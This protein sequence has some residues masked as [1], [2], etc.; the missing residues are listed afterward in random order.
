MTQPPKKDHKNL[1]IYG[2]FILL[3]FTLWIPLLP[4]ITFWLLPLPFLLFAANSQPSGLL[5]LFI[6]I[7]GGISLLFGG[8]ILAAMII[9]A[10]ITGSTMGWI[11]QRKDTTGLEVFMSGLIS[12]AASLLVLTLIANHLYGLLDFFQEML[13]EQWTAMGQLLQSYGMEDEQLLGDPLPISM[14]LPSM[15]TYLSLITSL[16]N[17]WIGRRILL[18]WK[19]PGKYLPPFRNWR[20][21]RP[22]FF[23][24]FIVTL[25]AFFTEAGESYWIT[26][27]SLQLL[28]WQLFFLQ[29]FAFVAFLL[30][31]AGKGRI[32]LA[33]V[34]AI[35]LLLPPVALIIHIL[36]ILDTG[37]QIRQFLQKGKK[38]N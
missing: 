25:I 19:F 30:H 23:F 36:G 5:P 2:L 15:I 37:T 24:Y 17:L 27:Q 10:A 16:I 26:I 11:Y 33:L 3:L 32:W 6:L 7:C 29:G 20:L 38:K 12:G 4:L 28:L 22:F 34:I 14:F 21:P 1:F 13:E 35:S 8:P 31:N 18:R 9:F